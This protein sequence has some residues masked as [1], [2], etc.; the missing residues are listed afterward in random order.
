L[1]I[2]KK[3]YE[4]VDAEM[5]AVL[6]QAEALRAQLSAMM[7][8][9]VEAFNQ[10]MGAYGLPKETESEKSARSQAIQNAL[11]TAT[12]VPLACA[13]ACVEV[14]ALS[15][16]AAEKGNKNVVSDAGVAVLAAYAALKA[17]ALNVRVNTGVIR[18]TQFVDNSIAE[19]EA[20]LDGAEVSMREIYQEVMHRL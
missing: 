2:N 12:H 7:Q 4:A 13:R 6:L 19:L 1:T 14:I 17:A 20:I 10:V 18:D 3:A 8:L 11:K 5:R 15:R 9:D 16:I